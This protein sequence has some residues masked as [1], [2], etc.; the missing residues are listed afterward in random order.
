MKI[1][2][3]ILKRLG[4]I[5]FW[6]GEKKCLDEL[7]RI[8]AK[9]MKKAAALA[10]KSAV[11]IGVT[12]CAGAA[13]MSEVRVRQTP[14]GPK[15]FENG[16]PINPRVCY[17]RS[18]M[19][20]I[21][22]GLDWKRVSYKTTAHHTMSV[23][24]RVRGSAQQ[25]DAGVE[26]RN[27]SLVDDATGK[28]LA[29]RLGPFE[30]SKDGQLT[31]TSCSTPRMGPF[32]KGKTYTVSFEVRADAETFIWPGLYQAPGTS[33][34]YTYYCVQI[35]P[36]DWTLTSGY[37]E[38]VNARK[39]GIRLFT[40]YFPCCFTREDNF[41]FEPFDAE[42]DLLLKAVPDALFF[43]RINS[44]AIA[45]WY[46]KHPEAKIVLQDGRTMEFPSVSSREFR[47]DAATY[48]AAC[49]RHLAEKY[50][51]N[52]AGIQIGGQAC[53]EWVLMDGFA[54]GAGY[55]GASRKAYAAWRAAKGL[56]PHEPPTNEERRA[57]Q[58]G[59]RHFFDPASTA[60]VAEFNDFLRHELADCLGG[61]AKVAQE[62]TNGK[63]M[64]LAF[65]S[66]AWEHSQNYR[67]ASIT[68]TAGLEYM[69]EKY[70]KYFDVM[71]APIT[72]S[73]RGWLGTCP[74]IGTV[75]T[76]KRHGILWMNE[77]DFRTPDATNE[78]KFFD[79]AHDR[80]KDVDGVFGYVWDRGRTDD[81]LLRSNASEAI[82]GLGEWWMDLGGTGWFEDPRYWQ[83]VEKTKALD[84]KMLA[85]TTP[86]EPEVA[87][88]IDE[89]SLMWLA[90]C[91]DSR[92]AA[93]QAR[94][95]IPR[96]GLPL[97]QYLYHDAID[98]PPPKAKLM[99]HFMSYLAEP[100]YAAKV[101]RLRTERP[102][103]SHV[104]C[105]AP[106][107]VGKKGYDVGGVKAL[108]GFT[109]TERALTNA[110]VQATAQGR[111]VGMT[112]PIGFAE[113][114]P[115]LGVE[116]EAGDEVW[117]TWADGTAAIVLRR[118]ANGKGFTAF[119]GQAPY[120]EPI[121]YRALADRAGAHAYLPRDRVGKAVVFA[122]DGVACVQSF[123]S[124]KFDFLKPDGGVIPLDLRK[125]EV[126]ILE[127]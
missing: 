39:V 76:L 117:G 8:Y 42:V 115:S 11:L 58:P 59:G 49:V 1:D 69:L 38:A 110:L 90:S 51:N 104:W 46:K 72:Y 71:A 70:G 31:Q 127:Y 13:E 34:V 111:A 78:G 3:P 119:F 106:G 77:D 47:H 85:R 54:Y 87:L 53:N 18:V 63:K 61:L 107:Y 82:R 2:T 56:P 57:A 123:E 14:T 36:D 124:A 28:A 97:G 92:Q 10:L 64:V 83:A 12:S 24:Y 99:I 21:P 125:G 108:T 121:I 96:A 80:G 84:A 32:V 48:I 6:R 122:T 112:K 86:F 98:N 16:V 116:T 126:K 52:Y 40:P 105:W 100:E 20:R 5:P 73:D 114:N 23:Q 27:F 17:T 74:V 79:P 37:K 19:S 26:I 66:Y 68:G 35:P 93:A 94:K 25:P 45:W 30:K 101:A 65:Y 88:T 81:M 7:Q 75:E 41:D 109:V 102:D 43:P 50:P 33:D 62:A 9:A 103:I 95:D 91:S 15:I 55:C 44:N 67:G 118:H 29:G 113:S 89:S 22:V 120:G 4:P 60:Y